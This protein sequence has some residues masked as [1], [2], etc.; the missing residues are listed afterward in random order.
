MGSGNC[1]EI[2]VFAP[3]NLAVIFCRR[4]DIRTSECNFFGICKCPYA[5]SGKTLN[6]HWVLI[7]SSTKVLPASFPPCLPLTQIHFFFKKD[8]WFP[9]IVWVHVR[10]LLGLY[11][12]LS[13][14]YRPTTC[15]IGP[16]VCNWPA[17][18]CAWAPPDT[19]QGKWAIKEKRSSQYFC[20]ACRIQCW[21]NDFPT[22]VSLTVQFPF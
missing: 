22:S 13:V 11:Y 7:E 6:Q 5:T 2:L 21:F 15:I 20:T 12:I 19:F 3:I 10:H 18:K 1:G 8:G 9:C 16:E 14:H 4:L 17:L